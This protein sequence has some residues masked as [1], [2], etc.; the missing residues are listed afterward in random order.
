MK[1]HHTSGSLNYNLLGIA[2]ALV[3]WEL[4]GRALG[5]DLFAPPTVVL[6]EEVALLR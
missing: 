6:P 1:A 2:V 3:A 4:I 5:A